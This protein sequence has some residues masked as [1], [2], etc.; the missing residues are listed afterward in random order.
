M[1]LAVAPPGARWI[2][3][4]RTAIDD[5]YVRVIGDMRGVGIVLAWGGVRAVIVDRRCAGT[6]SDERGRIKRMAPEAHV[7][8]VCDDGEVANADAQRWPDDRAA[9]RLLLGI[10]AG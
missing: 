3:R 10:A 9:A 8:L 2:A 7:I 1:I 5:H 6:W 4:A